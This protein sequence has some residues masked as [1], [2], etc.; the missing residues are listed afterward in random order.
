MTAL[1]VR[2]RKPDPDPEPSHADD[3]KQRALDLVQ[4]IK[5]KLNELEPLL[6]DGAI[7]SEGDD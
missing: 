3:A 4:E 7:E 5:K 1:M 2:F 6:A